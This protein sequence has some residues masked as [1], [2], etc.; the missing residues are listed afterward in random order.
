MTTKEI[1]FTPCGISRKTTTD[2]IDHRMPAQHPAFDQPPLSFDPASGKYIPNNQ[3]LVL[4]SNNLSLDSGLQVAIPIPTISTMSVAL[5]QGEPG[6]LGRQGE[7]LVPRE[8]IT[9]I[10]SM[11]FWSTI[12]PDALSLLCGSSD[13]PKGLSD[14]GFSI[15]GKQGWQDIHDT[16][17]AAKNKYQ[18]VKGP[19]G[20]MSR[21]RRKLADKSA[22]VSDLI[23]VVDTLV[24]DSTYAT[25]IVGTVKVIVNATNKSAQVRGEALHSF[26]DI[27]DV[28]S[29][30][31]LFLSLFPG[32]QN[33]IEASTDL[34]III[35]KAVEQAIVFFL[36][37][38]VKRGLK[39]LFGGDDYGKDL[40]D[41]VNT[42]ESKSNSL[43][44]EASKSYMF[45]Q[46]MRWKQ[47]QSFHNYAVEKLGFMASGLSSMND[48]FTIHIERK[49][50][51]LE[52]SR[53]ALEASRHETLYYKE[54]ALRTPSPLPGTPWPVPLQA[55]LPDQ[56]T[57]RHMIS[58]MDVDLRDISL[59]NDR[60]EEMSHKQRARAEQIVSSTLFEQWAVST[61]S[62]KLLVEW[63]NPRADSIA[64]I[65]PLTVFCTTMA[66]ALRARPRFISALW[67]CGRH[68]DRSDAGGCIG[69][70]AMLASLI[71]QILRQHVF[72]PWDPQTEINLDLLQGSHQSID[73]LLKLLIWLVRRIP[74]TLT[75]FFIIDGVYLFERDEFWSD[76]RRV[77]LGILRLVKDVP[78]TVKVLFTSAPGTTIVR[79]GFEQEGLILSVDELPNMAWA[80]SDERMIREMG[81]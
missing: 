54:I 77:F 47:T 29:P 41:S 75:V 59:V 5:P 61:A 16:L 69:E 11:K 55:Q 1:D 39:A 49:D 44:D 64:G 24:P 23:K 19:L 66:Q 38:S 20:Q 42:I 34:T 81:I 63:D 56:N 53:Q 73:E 26:D 8:A 80:P 40:R 31:E 45:Q 21:I 62:A 36:S 67:F 50:R 76:A 48:L 3:A 32:D 58:S 70:R 52:A 43:M 7:Q 9:N 25:P 37:N 79:G 78:A 33:I 22:P 65:S 72:H 68:F 13:E 60:K 4:A 28:F 71:D 46:D 51:E 12:L 27:L 18:D 17:E 35:L 30:V 57:L 14:A 6:F 74:Q 2:F 10:H 15:R